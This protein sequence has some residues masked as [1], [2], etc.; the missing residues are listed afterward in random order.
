M[1]EASAPPETLAAMD[2]RRFLQPQHLAEVAGQA[3]GAAHELAAITPPDDP[4]ERAFVRLGWRAMA[5]AFEM[6]MPLDTPDALA[7]GRE[8]FELLDALEDQLTVYRPHSEVSRINR[9]APRQAVR[10][11]AGLFGLLDLARQIHADT[12][13]AYDVAIGSLLEVWG[14]V[15]GPRRVPADAERGEAIAVSGMAHVSLDAERRSV[16]LLRPGVKI[17]L[18]SIGKG[19]ALDR[20]ADRLAARGVRNA[21]IHGGSSSVV[22]RGDAHGDG[23]AVRI[24][25]PVDTTS[26]I[27]E[28]RLR[29]QALGTSAATFQFLEHEGRR[30]GHI[31]DPRTGWPASGVASVSV[32]APSGTLAD[33]LSTAF[34]IG[35]IE[36]ARAYCESH[37]NI[38]AI[39]LPEEGPVAVFGMAPGSYN[40]L[41]SN[42]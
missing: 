10:V 3:L 17:N 4:D 40:L 2:R 19:Y 36:L 29:D 27:A 42:P 9:L 41:T 30:L 5:T 16:R 14:F 33:A 31:L 11:E 1:G 35:G 38:G 8:A 37:S 34:Y 13:G 24:R 32:V 39:L 15:R 7:A 21:L 18:G 20:M 12:G 26:H 28:V 23:W 25:H 22:A 6:L